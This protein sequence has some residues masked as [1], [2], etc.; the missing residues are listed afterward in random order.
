MCKY[1]NITKLIAMLIVSQAS[2]VSAL[3]LYEQESTNIN[4][5]GEIIIANKI[6]NSTTNKST[7]KL[8]SEELDSS[9]K[10]TVSNNTI[11]DLTINGVVEAGIVSVSRNTKNNS[12]VYNKQTYIQVINTNFGELIVGKTKSV[13]NEYIME[14]SVDK[15]HASKINAGLTYFSKDEGS[16]YGVNYMKK[17]VIYKH[18]Y[19]NISIGV[20]YQH[21]EDEM[22]NENGDIDKNKSRSFLL[23]GAIKYSSNSFSASGGYQTVKILNSSS[24]ENPT[25]TDSDLEAHLFAGSTSYKIGNLYMA[26]AIGY[27]R[28][29]ISFSEDHIS[30]AVY[31]EYA[32]N[33]ITPYIAYEAIYGINPNINN[34]SRA[35]SVDYSFDRSNITIG[36]RFHASNSLKLDIEYNQDIRTTAQSN[37]SYLQSSRPKNVTISMS[38]LF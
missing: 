10:L 36:G 37:T 21:K 33:K 14:S 8:E 9:I 25:F 19:N 24:I 31:I 5:S 34:G 30:G 22:L 12:T 18:H 1:K 15:I 28:N 2:T 6:G 13:F 35:S 38:Y 3:E 20:N 23:G 29:Y 32:L 17:A 16:D 7:N 4:L 11:D 26:S 27:Y